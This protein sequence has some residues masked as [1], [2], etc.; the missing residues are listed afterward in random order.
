MTGITNMHSASSAIKTNTSSSIPVNKILVATEVCSTCVPVINY[1]A[2]LANLLNAELVI[3]NIVNS[4]PNN[5]Q[6]INDDNL[7]KGKQSIIHALKRMNIS[8]DKVIIMV[9]AG[10]P[11][12]IIN[13]TILTHNIGLCI[14]GKSKSRS[15]KSKVGKL[16]GKIIDNPPC[17]LAI[18]TPGQRLNLP[19]NILITWGGV[20][21]ENLTHHK[22]FFDG[23]LN[24]LNAEDLLFHVSHSSEKFNSD[25]V[26]SAFKNI[27]HHK[28][29]LETSHS[30]NVYLEIKKKLSTEEFD[31]VIVFHRINKSADDKFGGSLSKKLSFSVE[32]PVMIIPIHN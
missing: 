9:R 29:E 26:K 4:D 13:K 16:T 20:D 1:G 14:M 15:D 22:K 23:F 7:N 3:L 27:L 31:M 11:E 24:N 12:D 28:V 6:F 32:T 2:G 8:P 5:G 30:D 10:D 21:L 17:P 18:I 25:D 19:S